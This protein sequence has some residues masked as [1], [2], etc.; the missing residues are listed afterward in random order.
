MDE[1]LILEIRG[2]VGGEEAALF[3]ADLFSMYQKFAV[4]QGWTIK[5][6]DKSLTNLGGL[7]SV[8]LEIK[9]N[10]A[11]T[12]LKSE[13]G[14]HRIQRIPETE[15]SGRV[16]TSTVTVAVLPILKVSELKINPQDLRIDFYRSGGAGGQNVNKVET[17]VRITH[18][19]TGVVSACQTERFQLA[20]REKAMQILISKLQNEM[21]S[22]K[23]KELS[24]LRASQVGS[25]DRADKIRTYNFPQDRITDHRIKKSWHNIGKIMNGNLEPI[26]KAFMSS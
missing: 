26:V 8:T 15:K 18:I 11:Y 20:N 16:H 19:P 9:G 10:D 12:K 14:V 13:S 4:S 2:G 22:S 21:E 25:A 1:S 24:Q 23:T 6:I 7:K 3:G 17:A 5:S